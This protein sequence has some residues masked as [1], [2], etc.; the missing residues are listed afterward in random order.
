AGPWAGARPGRCRGPVPVAR[1]GLPRPS[2]PGRG[3][4]PWHRERWSWKGD[5]SS[6]AFR[7]ARPWYSPH[8]GQARWG[9]TGSP[10]FGQAPT[11]GAVAFQCARRW[12]RFCRLG[13]FFGT[14]LSLLL[15]L[16]LDG[17]ERRP[18]WVQR[19]L[20]APAV[21]GVE[22]L[23]AHRAQ[24]LAS[25]VAERRRRRGE[26][27][28]LPQ[29]GRQI[30]GLAAIGFLVDRLQI[31]RGRR[32]RLVAVAVSLGRLGSDALAWNVGERQVDGLVQA[33]LLQAPLALSFEGDREPGLEEDAAAQL[34]EAAAN[35]GGAPRMELGGRLAPEHGVDELPGQVGLPFL[36][37][38]VDL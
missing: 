10:H 24:A 29:R 23:A 37:R 18:A 31:E 16:E 3:H 1:A 32:A 15:L 2:P 4:R 38:L 34:G 8:L 33:H 11:F 5:Q 22:V 13:R 19:G 30:D 9:S 27:D 25:L 26:Q 20:L 36:A 17:L 14:P 28:L 6:L 21:A 7:T 35:V 12:S